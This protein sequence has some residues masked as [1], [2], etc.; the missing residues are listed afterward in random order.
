[1][2]LKMD[3]VILLV[4]QEKVD[5]GCKGEYGKRVQENRIYAGLQYEYSQ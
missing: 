1:M 3:S 4:N 2:G 5:L